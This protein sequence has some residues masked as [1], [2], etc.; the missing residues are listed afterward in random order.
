MSSPSVSRDDSLGKR[1]GCE[2]LCLTGRGGRAH[3]LFRGQRHR[4]VAT[5]VTRIR[6]GDGSSRP[7]DLPVASAEAKGELCFHCG[8]PCAGADFQ[9]N[10]QAFCCA[11]CRTVYELLHENGLGHFYDL[12]QSAGT[13]TAGRSRREQLAFLDDPS[14]RGKLLDFSDG[15]TA[16][17]T[18]HVP[19]V[20]CIACVW[21]LENLFRLQPGIGR[22]TVHFPRREVSIQFEEATVKLSDVAGLL[23]ALGYEPALNLGELD[24][25]PAEVARR[26]RL[27]LKLGLAGFGFGNIMLFSI[28]IYSGLD[29][30]SGAG[31][32]ALFGWLSAVL[33]LPV[34]VYSASD[35]WRAAWLGLRRR[36]L[37]IDLPISIGLAAITAQSLWEVASG[38]GEG[39]FDSLTGLIFFLLIGRVFQEKLYDRLNFDR[40]YR[41]FFPLAVVRVEAGR[42]VTVP[43]SKLHVGDRLLVRNGE[44]VPA[45]ARVV[46]GQGVIDYSFVTGEAAAVDKQEGDLV[47]AGGRQVG[48]TLEVET[49]KPV[50]QSY[51]TS[52]WSHQ[53]FAKQRED[54]LDSALNRFT[55]RFT[56]T[57]GAVAVTAAV[58]W[59]WQGQPAVALKA[60]VSVLIVACPCALALSAP[61][62]LGTAQRRL[63]QSNIFLKNPQVIEAL[64][65]VNAV[66]FDKTGTL[67][68]SGSG[69]VVFEGTPLE[70]GEQAQIRAVLQRSTH[71]HAVRITAALPDAL[72]PGV[73]NVEEVPGCGVRGSVSGSVWQLGSARWLGKS[74]VQI[75]P[76]AEGASVQVALDRRYRGCFRLTN[77]LRAESAA[78]MGDLSARCELA[79]LSG[80]HAH[81]RERFLA[82]FG[83]PAQLH[84][85]QSPVDKL[86]FID[87]LQK[88]GRRV[89][90]V[91]DGLND[92]GAL[93][94]SDVGV[95]VVENVGAFSPASDVILEAGRVRRLGAVLTFARGTVRVV[96]LSILLS[97]LY[98]LVGL[99]IAASGRLS[100]VVCAI[101]M[102]LSSVSVVA[103]AC[104]ATEWMARRCGW[105]GPRGGD[106]T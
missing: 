85:N 15:K 46:S 96:W 47:Q 49:V 35:Y 40:D 11:G 30:F 25:K 62:A 89:M 67:T 93:R 22:S 36:L 24:R 23:T 1:P 61:F 13:R 20:H 87:R 18:F 29:S 59:L 82:L 63:G 72:R 48:G 64:A 69:D 90:M 33:A 53:A 51:L 100:P 5:V 50:S 101:L 44:L 97:S 32:K 99:A 26:R 83:R 6:N 102:P 16:R 84:F 54:S 104:G 92:A 9:R 31:F 42:E 60:F 91:G 78:L 106:P 58:W 57:V 17:V 43:I 71:P 39:F 4:S 38:T 56:V 94:Q 19:A 7:G 74:G 76:A 98:N 105:S 77:A 70:P 55:R 80:D 73:G 8:T 10:G 52:L 65:R 21:L 103:F 12:A 68:E 37:T 95:A 14:V 41:A 81:E 28:S 45:D 2:L 3:P 34:V 86:G 66:V 79:L 88:A 75:P 27:H